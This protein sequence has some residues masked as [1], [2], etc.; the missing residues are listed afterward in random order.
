[1]YSSQYPRQ[2]PSLCQLPFPNKCAPKTAPAEALPAGWFFQQ[3]PGLTGL[4]LPCLRTLSDRSSL[5]QRT[6]ELAAFLHLRLPAPPSR[7]YFLSEARS[8]CRGTYWTQ[9]RG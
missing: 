5:W 4:P 2:K 9:L 3:N 7:G 6:R 1:Q 8:C